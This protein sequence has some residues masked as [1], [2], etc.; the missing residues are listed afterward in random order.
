VGR[1]PEK[2][3]SPEE[4]QKQ[5][6]GLYVEQMFQRKGM[7]SLVFPKQKII[8]SLSWLAREMREHSKSVFVVEGLQ[9]SWLGTTGQRVAYGAVV[10]LAGAS[11]RKR[12]RVSAFFAQS[13]RANLLLAEACD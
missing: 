6:F 13:K 10:A 11:L 8:G 3:D 12:R 7:I 5:I 1:L 9:S 2:G 4:R